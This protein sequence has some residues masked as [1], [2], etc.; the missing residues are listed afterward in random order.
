MQCYVRADKRVLVFNVRLLD[1][2]Y[3]L[4]KAIR[5]VVKS[6]YTEENDR[7]MPLSFRSYGVRE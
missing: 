5:A 3:G 7:E 1:R 6:T 2:K 4:E